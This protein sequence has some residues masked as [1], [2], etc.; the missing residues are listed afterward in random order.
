MSRDPLKTKCTRESWS[1]EMDV[2]P[3]VERGT[4]ARPIHWQCDTVGCTKEGTGSH[5]WWPDHEGQ[6]LCEDCQRTRYGWQHHPGE[7]TLMEQQAQQQKL[8]E[9]KVKQVGRENVAKGAEVADEQVAQTLPQIP[10][11]CPT[12]RIFS[13]LAN[14]QGPVGPGAIRRCEPCNLKWVDPYPIFGVCCLCGRKVTDAD[15]PEPSD[16]EIG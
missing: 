1:G 13:G 6:W 14:G 9:E 4:K 16:M 11:F 15:K 8:A 5:G 12:T 3:S 7:K 2:S 10:G